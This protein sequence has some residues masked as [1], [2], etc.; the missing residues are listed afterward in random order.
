MQLFVNVDVVEN[1]MKVMIRNDNIA[2]FLYGCNYMD[3]H[4]LNWKLIGLYV[5]F[6]VPENDSS[7]ES[8]CDE[9]YIPGLTCYCNEACRQYENCCVDYYEICA[10][11]WD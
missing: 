9:T 11:E 8:R 1:H 6:L 3:V 7:C 10:R 5:T 4:T 2:L